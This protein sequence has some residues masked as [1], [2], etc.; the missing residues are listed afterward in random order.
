MSASRKQEP[1]GSASRRAAAS[2]SPSP[3]LE[4]SSLLWLSGP[5]PRRRTSSFPT[6][7]L[8]LHGLL[9]CLVD[10]NL[11]LHKTKMNSHQNWTKI[12]FP[13]NYH[14]SIFRNSEVLYLPKMN[15]I[16]QKIFII[17]PTTSGFFAITWAAILE[18]WWLP[19]FP[20]QP[21][22]MK[23]LWAHCDMLTGKFYR[24]VFFAWNI[25]I[26]E[27]RRSSTTLLWTKIRMPE[28]SG[29][30]GKKSNRSGCRLVKPRRSRPWEFSCTHFFF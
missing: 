22:I 25:A 24:R 14:T 3:L 20:L 23:R 29:N 11:M 4:W 2:T 21:I 27:R 18:L 17:Q 12:P 28:S 15:L 19:Q 30:W 7:T 6:E 8:S 10:R 16:P 5:I 1:W 13:H 26:S 9:F